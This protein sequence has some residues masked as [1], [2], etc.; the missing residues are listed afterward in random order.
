VGVV[1]L[2]NTATGMSFSAPIVADADGKLSY[3]F[4]SVPPGTYTLNATLYYKGED[5]FTRAY[6][7]IDQQGDLVSAL[8]V[9][10]SGSTPLQLDL[11]MRLGEHVCATP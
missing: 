9:D 6:Q 2:K 4:A 10:V 8:T 3:T 5:G 1:Q 11:A 7:R